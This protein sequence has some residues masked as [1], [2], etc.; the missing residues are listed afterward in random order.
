MK[1]H[2]CLLLF[3]YQKFLTLLCGEHGQQQ[4]LALTEAQ[5][6]FNSMHSHILICS[7]FVKDTRIST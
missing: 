1:F 6:R 5:T 3:I 2:K 7:A 4:T